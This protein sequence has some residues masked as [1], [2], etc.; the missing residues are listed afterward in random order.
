MREREKKRN[1]ER[2]REIYIDRE[3]ERKKERKKEKERNISLISYH[4]DPIVTT[5]LTYTLVFSQTVLTK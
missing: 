5:S 2:E 4:L 3:R 1:N